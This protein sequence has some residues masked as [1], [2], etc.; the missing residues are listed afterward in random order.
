MN[1]S[2]TIAGYP[3]IYNKMME[4]DKKTGYLPVNGSGEKE[5]AWQIFWKW[6]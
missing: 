6:H 1:V 2:V 4:S 5:P 3:G